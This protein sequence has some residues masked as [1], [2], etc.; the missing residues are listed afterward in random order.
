MQ[1]NEVKI[2]TRITKT[3]DETQ[4]HIAKRGYKPKLH[5]IDNET[6]INTKK[7][8]EQTF[9]V[10]VEIVLPHCHRRNLAERTIRT[11]KTT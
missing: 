11:T 9:G 3:Y 4:I 8:S 5:Q 2:G 1:T 10:T 6:S 7:L